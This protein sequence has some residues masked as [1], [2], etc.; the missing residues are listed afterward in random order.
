MGGAGGRSAKSNASDHC[1]FLGA[2]ACVVAGSTS[3]GIGQREGQRMGRMIKGDHR[4]WRPVPPK[5]AEVVVAVKGSGGVVSL[6]D[7]AEEAH[8]SRHRA[9][10]IVA[11]SQATRS[12]EVDSDGV[13]C[14]DKALMGWWK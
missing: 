14:G 4:W 10:D 2:W 5:V 11:G 6:M 7:E 3:G 13:R 12:N 8:P 9:W 1:T